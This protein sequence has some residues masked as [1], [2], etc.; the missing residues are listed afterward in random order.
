MRCVTIT[1]LKKKLSYYINLCN[2]EDIFITK[3]GEVV[4]V[5]SNPDEAYYRKLTKLYGCLNDNNP[6]QT[7]EEMIGEEIMRRCGY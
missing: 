4:A 1:E 6:N 7:Y 5:L 3:N 2:E